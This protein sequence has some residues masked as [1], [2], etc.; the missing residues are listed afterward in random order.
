M[1]ED[2]VRCLTKHDKIH[3]KFQGLYVPEVLKVLPTYYY[4]GLR[5]N[6]NCV[7][8]T[9]S[10]AASP[11]S[12]LPLTNIYLKFTHRAPTPPVRQSSNSTP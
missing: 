9:E 8:V 11:K 6:I 5:I 4:L 2:S 7:G 1:P 3:R 10:F 12:P